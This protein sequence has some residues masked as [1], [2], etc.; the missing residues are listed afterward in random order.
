MRI[1]NK[2]EILR[3]F[4]NST[5]HPTKFITYC[6]NTLRTVGCIIINIKY[7]NV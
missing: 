5:I 2:S 6:K 1:A 3:M 7:K 4:P